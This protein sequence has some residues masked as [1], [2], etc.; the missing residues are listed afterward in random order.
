MCK[1]HCDVVTVAK[2]HPSR[3]IR[4][5]DSLKL[6][7]SK[8]TKFYKTPK[9][10]ASLSSRRRAVFFLHGTSA[11]YCPCLQA[12]A[13]V[14]RSPRRRRDGGGGGS[15]RD[16]GSL[17]VAGRLDETGGRRR[18]TRL[19]VTAALPLSSQA[20]VRRAVRLARTEA[21]CEQRTERTK[22]RRSR[23]G[24]R[25]RR[26]PDRMV[27]DEQSNGQ[28]AA[29]GGRRDGRKRA[30]QQDGTRRSR[31]RKPQRNRRGRR[32]RQN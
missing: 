18:H 28:V 24:K 16:D 15:G 25:R 23:P 29:S 11:V 21:V 19:V 31:K 17:L 13:V 9:S 14:D 5:G 2:V 7:A 8:S 4:A 12:A 10:S 20:L 26:R 1:R 6:L 22:D 3:Y 32:P 27:S 30:R